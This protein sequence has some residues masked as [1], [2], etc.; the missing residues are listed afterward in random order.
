MLT[1]FS[2]N[3][4]VSK[5][6]Y[7][8]SMTMAILVVLPIIT[9]FAHANAIDGKNLIKIADFKVNYSIGPA[10]TLDSTPDHKLI[11]IAVNSNNGQ[12]SSLWLLKTSTGSNLTKNQLASSQPEQLPLAKSFNWIFNPRLSPDG[13][14]ILFIGVYQEK[15]QAGEIV[16]NQS[17]FE[18][19]LENGTLFEPRI[20]VT[21]I[22]SADWMPNGSL[23]YSG[24]DQGNNGDSIWIS[25]RDGTNSRM[26]FNSSESAE[27]L[28]VS[29]DGNKVAFETNAA[30]T[31]ATLVKVLDVQTGKTIAINDI[32]NVT[33]QTL[34]RYY[35]PRWLS[36]D[37]NGTMDRG[38]YFIVPFSQDGSVVQ[39]IRLISSDG[40]KNILLFQDSSLSILSVAPTENGRSIIILG[41][42]AIQSNNPQSIGIYDL[43][44][45]NPIAE[46]SNLSLPSVLIVLLFTPFILLLRRLQ[47]SR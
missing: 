18:Y 31:Q 28:A 10:I 44:L 21:S 42:A 19:G 30:P 39:Q 33:N 36:D 12:N 35:Q 46:F 16:T 40:N 38:S 25:N 20:S 8:I 34:G 43:Q 45:A 17:L 32:G 1:I 47:S 4:M 22:R 3:N 11:T 23:L 41:T 7:F 5:F 6:R 14:D 27:N 37:N 13:R 2:K 15:N 29:R 24:F 9:S 26:V